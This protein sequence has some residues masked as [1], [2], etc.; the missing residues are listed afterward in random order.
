MSA[1]Q[2]GELAERMARNLRRLEETAS[3]LAALRATFELTRAEMAGGFVELSEATTVV[4]RAVAEARGLRG[5]GDKRI[6][7]WA[8]PVRLAP[9]A[10][11]GSDRTGP[12][13]W[14]DL[15][16]LHRTYARTRDP[17]L[18]DRLMDAYDPFA[19]ALAGQFRTRREG[20]EDLLQVA[21]IGLLAAIDRFDPDL[22][23]PFPVFARVTIG[24]ELK[25]H[26]RDRTWSMRVPRSLQEDYLCVMRAVE[27]LTAKL[28]AS[29]SMEEVAAHCGLPLDRVVDAMDLGLAQRPLSLDV[30]AIDGVGFSL[31][32]G[33]EDLGFSRID[34]RDVVRKL[35]ARLP[36]RDRRIIELR[37]VEE[38]SQ[39]EIAGVVGVSQMCVSRTLARS[40]GRLRGWV[41]AEAV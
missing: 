14:T 6:R 29:P 1:P 36:D 35:V 33:R 17:A 24:G 25:R 27:E 4:R 15:P 41:R 39:S 18:R 13:D 23:R 37:F 22:G 32:P 30:P 31:D 3:R 7:P 5:R 40:L 12:S 21:R 26:I 34:R 20:F 2:P 16:E 10:A 38:L 28:A 8:P 9:V 19:R 11:L